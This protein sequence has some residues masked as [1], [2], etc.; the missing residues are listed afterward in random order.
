MLQRL[1]SPQLLHEA[2]R[3]GENLWVRLP[4][5]NHLMRTVMQGLVMSAWPS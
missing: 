5:V 3:Q 1:A 4:I 2:F